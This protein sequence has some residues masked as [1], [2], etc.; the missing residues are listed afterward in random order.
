MNSPFDNAWQLLKNWSAPGTDELS[1]LRAFVHQN[2]NS[3]DPEKRA[4]AEQLQQ[5]ITAGEEPSPAPQPA[6]PQQ[7][8]QAPI[9]S[10]MESMRPTPEMTQDARA[11]PW[12]AERMAQ[13]HHQ[14]QRRMIGE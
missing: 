6:P 12:N 3:A 14:S 7:P 5:Q 13:Q 8:P 11:P 10:A 2:L 4:R 1:E 9:D